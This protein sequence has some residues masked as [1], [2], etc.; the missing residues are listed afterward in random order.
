MTILNTYNICN[1]NINNIF[2][3][4]ENRVQLLENSLMN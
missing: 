3:N 4:I 2:D 1:K